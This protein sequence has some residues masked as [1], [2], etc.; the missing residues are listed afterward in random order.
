[1]KRLKIALKKEGMD[2]NLIDDPDA[3]LPG[4]A[5]YSSSEAKN[6]AYEKGLR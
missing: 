3:I 4:Q 1:M 2:E 5:G 6:E